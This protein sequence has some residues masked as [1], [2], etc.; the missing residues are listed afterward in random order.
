MEKGEI[1]KRTLKE[2]LKALPGGLF[3]LVVLAAPAVSARALDWCSE[4]YYASEDVAWTLCDKYYRERFK[5]PN[6]YLIILE[7]SSGDET[8]QETVFV[9]E[10]VWY[11][12]KIG[13]TVM[14]PAEIVSNWEHYV[15][16][17]D[18]ET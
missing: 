1:M 5:T 8:K 6:S 17:I 11:G 14:Y 2:F 16:G 18:P 10:E 9:E 12:Y 15:K 7:Y 4:P 13:D 3:V